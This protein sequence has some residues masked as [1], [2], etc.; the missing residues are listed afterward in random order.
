MS[1]LGREAARAKV[2]LNL[3][4]TGRDAEGYH[5]LETLMVLAD[6][7]EDVVTLVGVAER[8]HVD[9]TGRFAGRLDGDGDNLVLAATRLVREAQPGLPPLA[10]TVAK[11]LPVAAGIGGGSADAGAALRLMGRT[12]DVC[13]AALRSIAGR[14]GADV[15]FA[16]GDRAGWA[17]ERGDRIAPLPVPPIAGILVNSGDACP[18]PAVFGAYRSGA[19]PFSATIE[20]PAAPDADTLIDWC[21]GTRNDLL[22]AALDVTP[23]IKH[24]L[25]ALKS[26]DACRL[27]RMSGSGA[28]CFGLFAA[29]ADAEAAAIALRDRHPEWWIAPVTLS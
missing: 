7:A 26:L 5:H 6:G 14:L 24:V 1:S 22:D 9:V 18:T 25:A 19:Y 4:V 13:P 17:T 8:D 15:P 16:F 27:A 12:F 2:N 29:S 11:K 10:W 21:G 23:S 28:T 3:H 20:G